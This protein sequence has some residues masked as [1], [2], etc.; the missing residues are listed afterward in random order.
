MGIRG[1]DPGV[2]CY[3]DKLGN[4]NRCVEINNEI[5]KN[6]DQLVHFSSNN[7]NVPI[8]EV[9]TPEPDVNNQLEQLKKTEKEERRLFET[10]QRKNKIID[11]A[12]KKQ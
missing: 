1:D 6:V 7:L 12:K 4:G 9:S 2:L 11:E 8:I 3:D 5:Y 10:T